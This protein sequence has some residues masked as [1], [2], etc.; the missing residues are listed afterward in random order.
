MLQANDLSKLKQIYLLHLS[1]N[2][3]D[4][5]RIKTEVQKIT[6]SEVYVA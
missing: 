4:E 6:G 1:D 2:N 5:R 3:S